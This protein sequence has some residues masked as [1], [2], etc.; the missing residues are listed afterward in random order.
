MFLKETFRYK[1]FYIYTEISEFK[2][3]I[4]SRMI[5]LSNDISNDKYF[6]NNINIF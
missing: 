1:I 3:I 5:F 6:C 4:S 2:N